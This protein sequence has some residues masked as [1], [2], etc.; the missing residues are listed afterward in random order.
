MS[1]VSCPTDYSAWN[2]AYFTL[3]GIEI[4]TLPVGG[5][6]SETTEMCGSTGT[7][8]PEPTPFSSRH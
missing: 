3:V 8:V 1:Q 6:P 2:E 5:F 7:D 4:E